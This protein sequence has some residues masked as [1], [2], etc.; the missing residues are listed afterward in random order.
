MGYSCN[1]ISDLV[2]DAMI[3]VMQDCG[4]HKCSNAWVV[5]GVEYFYE[6][7]RE[8]EDGS[9]TG[10]VMELSNAHK[11]GS[12]KISH[13]GKVVRFPTSRKV[14]RDKA[15]I[16]GHADYNNKFGSFVDSLIGA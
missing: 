13:D 7:G 16:V 8:Q 9:I 6:I 4:P 1:A 11:V 10:T 2:L 5:D 15:Q 3:K 12:F 14:H